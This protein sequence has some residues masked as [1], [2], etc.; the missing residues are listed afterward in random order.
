M[1]NLTKTD[2]SKGKSSHLKLSEEASGIYDSKYGNENFSTKLY[3]DYELEVIDKAVKLLSPNNKSIAIDLGCGTGRDTL[4]FCKNFSK[5]TGYDFSSS[6]I[7]IAI[8]N[9]NKMR[10]NNVD[11]IQ[12]D[13]EINGL[14]EIEGDSVSFVNAGFGMGSFVKDINSLIKEI[15]RILKPGGI[16]TI[17]FYNS[18]ALVSQVAKELSWEPSLSARFV[19]NKNSLKVAFQG[20]KFNIA[21][22]AYSVQECKKF[23]SRYFKVIELSTFPTVSSLLPNT[24]FKNQKVKNIFKQIDYTIRFDEKMAVGPYI[25]AICQKNRN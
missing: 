24:L 17:S 23:L 13:I 19:N 5:V 15:C 21:A 16:F 4:Y 14:K 10:V 1:N 8:K 11:F 7:K 2:W 3:M 22:K 20:N 6:M 12:K 9:V 25:I 18:S